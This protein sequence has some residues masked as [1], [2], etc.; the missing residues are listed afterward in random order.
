MR[1]RIHTVKMA[2]WLA[3]FIFHTH[4]PTHKKHTY[5]CELINL[6]IKDTFDPVHAY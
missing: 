3:S 4:T 2:K 5:H 1:T 6:L